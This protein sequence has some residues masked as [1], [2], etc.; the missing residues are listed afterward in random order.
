MKTTALTLKSTILASILLIV[1]ASPAYT[2]PRISKPL[3]IAFGSCVKKPDSPL[4]SIVRKETPDLLFL[5]GDNVYFSG[6]KVESVDYARNFPG[7]VDSLLNYYRRLFNNTDF[8]ALTQIVPLFAIWNDHDFGPDGAD[9]TFEG[10]RASF[11]AYRT[12]FEDIHRQNALDLGLSVSHLDWNSGIAFAF[13][14]NNLQFIFTD[15]RSYRL[16]PSKSKKLWSR[17][18][19]RLFGDNQLNWIRRKLANKEVAASLIISGGQLLS[20]KKEIRKN[21]QLKNFHVEHATFR[22]ILGQAERPV[23]ILSGDRHFS[24]VLNVRLNDRY[25]LEFTSSPVSSE[26]RNKMKNFDDAN[27]VGPVVHEKNFGFLSL[28]SRKDGSIRTRIKYLNQDGIIVYKRVF[29]R[30]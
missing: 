27:R 19:A 9:S 12:T 4:W 28:H 18:P 1:I 8:Y 15:D 22:A 7:A 10:R 25:F 29:D 13:I 14:Y 26:P 11:W 21:E 30:S 17:S 16:N 6:K 23:Y 5:L 3:N 24:E 2:T 20:D